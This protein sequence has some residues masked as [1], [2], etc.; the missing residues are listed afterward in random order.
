MHVQDIGAKNKKFK[1]LLVRKSASFCFFIELKSLTCSVSPEV[2]RSDSLSFSPT[3]SNHSH[4]LTVTSQ[5]YSRVFLMHTVSWL[6]P[7]VKDGLEIFRDS[8]ALQ[9]LCLEVRGAADSR[10]VSPPP[11]Y[12]FYF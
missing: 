9:I 11:I 2:Q 3:D 7:Q 10:S 1:P 6:H 5:S 4:S 12:F 8:S